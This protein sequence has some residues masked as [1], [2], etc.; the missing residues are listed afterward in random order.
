MRFKTR[1]FSGLAVAALALAGCSAGSD[2]S[3]AQTL[4][5][6]TAIYPLEYIAKSVGG[7]H[8]KV[9]SLTPPNVEAHDLELSP[10]TVAGL[11][12]ADS[13]IYLRKF[14]PAVDAAVD[15]TSST[16]SLDITSAAHLLPANED[17]HAHDHAEGE[18]DHGH[19]DDAEHDEHSDEAH[20]HGEEADHA[21]AGHDE[22]E[23]GHDD[24]ADHAEAG[25]D[26]HGHGDDA[27]HEEHD[28]EHHHHH[29]V[30]GMD[31]HFW[32]DPD[33]MV[34]VAQQV[35]DHLSEIDKA[36]AAD[37]QKNLE[38]L[39]KQLKDLSGT[40]TSSFKSCKRENFIVSHEA[41]GYLAQKT[42]L[43][44]IGVSGIEPE[45]APSPARLNEIA[46]IVKETGTTTLYT[47]IAISPKV[48]KVLAND[49][50]VKTTTLDPLENQPKDGEDY[51]SVMKKNI[52][53][54]QAGLECQ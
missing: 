19:G 42:G 14:Q 11:S 4:D 52:E 28:H 23:H 18:H 26:E 44:Q 39:K 1:I 24:D 47:E 21:E 46:K 3:K 34:S 2:S 10:K 13:V 5:I 7:D 51:L 8:V 49:L 35:S 15:Q 48:I 41:F 43:K 29:D 54:L 6:R 9:T 17:E 22:H 32:L 50:G 16:K 45:V 36:H 27:D 30:G 20:E 40:M 25:H 38:S 12:N 37:Y 53:V 33:R 31:P